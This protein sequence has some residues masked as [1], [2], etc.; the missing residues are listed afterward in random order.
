MHADK[1]KTIKLLK[2]V[3][4]QVD[5]LIKMCE[6][7]RYCIDIS[8]QILASQSILK[9]VNLEIL[10]GHFSHCITETLKNGNEQ[11]KD[12]KIEEL[13]SVLNKILN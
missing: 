7:N 3:R 10:K 5:G 4:G 8:T 1:E 6:E 12:K 11:D 9:K 13:V 2:T